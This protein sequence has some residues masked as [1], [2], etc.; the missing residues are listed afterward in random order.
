MNWYSLLL[1]WCPCVGAGTLASDTLVE[2]GSSLELGRPCSEDLGVRLQM[3]AKMVAKLLASL[4][5]V[6]DWGEIHYCPTIP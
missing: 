5:A 3:A 2:S 4:V 1:P 6:V